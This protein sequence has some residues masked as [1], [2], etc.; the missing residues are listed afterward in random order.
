MTTTYSSERE[1]VGTLL[2]T[3]WNDCLVAGPNDDLSAFPV[4]EDEHPQLPQPTNDPSNPARFLAW[5]FDYDDASQITF[6]GDVQVEGRVVFTACVERGV[7]DAKLR[8]M[9]EALAAIFRDSA[10]ADGSGIQF[11]E[12][13]PGTPGVLELDDAWYGQ[14]LEIPFTRFR[15][16]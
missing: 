1:R 4:G 10:T 5:E 9:V 8:A 13:K 16:A 14:T 7:G 6:G 12:G 15:N 2:A 11:F 3:Y